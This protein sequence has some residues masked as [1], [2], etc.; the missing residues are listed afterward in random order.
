MSTA[1]SK[2]LRPALVLACAAIL[3]QGSLAQAGGSVR[4]RH[5]QAIDLALAGDV[6]SAARILR[7]LNEE[8]MS[9]DEKDHVRLSLGRVLY[10]AHDYNGALKAYEGISA[11]GDAWFSAI[12]ERA[13]T[14]M[15]MDQPEEA[16]AQLKTIT[17]PIFK[18]RTNP[19]PYFLT[20]LAQLRVCAYPAMYK[21]IG[22]FKER[23]LARAKEWQAMESMDPQAHAN[24][25]ILSETIQKLNIVEAEAIQRLYIDEDL[26]KSQPSPPNIEKGDGQLSFPVVDNDEIWLDEVD[27]FKVRV[28]G[29]PQREKAQ[30]STSR[31]G[32]HSL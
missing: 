25:K 10:Q 11:G 27:N 19:E 28:S 1:F 6:K 16:L 8:K 20:A 22:L 30:A 2:A 4:D 24:L 23:F 13:W 14:H 17:S 18:N 15:Q 12:E 21:T 3:S 5:V 29:C 31:A 32:G 26:K 9:V 7:G